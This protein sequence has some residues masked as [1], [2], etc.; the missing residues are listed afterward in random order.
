MVWHDCKTDPPKT[1]GTYEEYE[2][3]DHLNRKKND[4][5]KS[6]LK[7]KSHLENMINVGLKK[8][9]TSGITGVNWRSD[10]LTWRAVIR[11]DGKK[12]NLGCF[13]DKND[14][15]KARLSKE[16]E[17]FGNEAPQRHLFKEFG[18]E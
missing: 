4:N 16:K 3:V 10:N 18:I 14:A 5:R 2:E 7:P 11:Y 1:Y 9:S 13:V 15:I 17:L 12:Y 6:N 8:N